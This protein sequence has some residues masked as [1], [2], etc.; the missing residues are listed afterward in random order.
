ME[1]P[2]SRERVHYYI[3]YVSME[4][5][6]VLPPVPST[7]REAKEDDWIGG[8]YIP[9]GSQIII[10]VRNLP[11]SDSDENKLTMARFGQ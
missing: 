10:P 9:K 4:S 3:W 1:F 8:H 11:D 2:P 6:R 5:L 7:L